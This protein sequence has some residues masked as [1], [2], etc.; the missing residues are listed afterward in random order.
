MSRSA[1]KISRLRSLKDAKDCARMMINSEPWVTLQFDYR[2][3]VAALRDRNREA[4]IAKIENRPVGLIVLN[5][6]GPFRGYVQAIGVWPEFRGGGIGGRLLKYAEARILREFPNVFLCV[7]SFNRGA[8]R[9][10]KRLG[11]R[12]IGEL[13]D[14]VVKGHSEFLMRKTVG[15]MARFKGRL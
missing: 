10:Y 14:Y 13:K 9:L 7:S 5:L 3:T 8:Q 6:V 12:K 11:Y 1:I 2:T 15:P 4:Y